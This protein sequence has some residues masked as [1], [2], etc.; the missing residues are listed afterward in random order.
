MDRSTVVTLAAAASILGIPCVL[1]HDPEHEDPAS[2]GTVEFP[3]S[4]T[5]E[6]QRRFNTAASILYSFYWER[7]D[8]T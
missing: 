2:L 6:A 5:P 8:P 3:V 7:A 1:A 4:C